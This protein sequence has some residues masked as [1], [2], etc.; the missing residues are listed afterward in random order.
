MTRDD[1]IN[2]YFEWLCSLVRREKN[3]GGIS[4]Q[5]LL[6]YLHSTKFTYSI[7]MDKNRAS[8]GINMRY[9]YGLYLGLHDAPD[10]LKGPCSVFEMMVALAVRCE[11]SIMDNPD[12]GDRTSQWFWLMITNLG[13]GSMRDDIFDKKY[14]KDVVNRF[15]HR[16]YEPDGHGGLFVVRNCD[17]D[18]RDLEIFTQMCFYLDTIN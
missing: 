8:D 14:V 5:K 3:S 15:L 17:Q 10:A 11:E 6:S 13:L 16:D 12:Y 7:K 18:L 1:V 4:Y 2:D 9:R